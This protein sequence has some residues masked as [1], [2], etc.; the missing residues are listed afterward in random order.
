V[1]Q[2]HS[3]A[4]VPAVVADRYDVLVDARFADEARQVLTAAV[5]TPVE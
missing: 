4:A 2:R 5:G 1:W 3:F